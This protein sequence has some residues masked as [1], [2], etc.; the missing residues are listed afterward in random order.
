MR[1]NTIRR[2]ELGRGCRKI[3]VRRVRRLVIG[4]GVLRRRGHRARIIRTLRMG[5]NAGGSVATGREVPTRNESSNFGRWK[6]IASRVSSLIV[7]RLRRRCRR[8]RGRRV[9]R[10][11]A[12][13]EGWNWHARIVSV[14]AGRWQVISLR[15]AQVWIMDE[16]RVLGRGVR[17]HLGNCCTQQVHNGSI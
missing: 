7:W 12:L 13:G 4:R 3:K 16:P 1:R 6:I 15:G 9:V 10:N 5:K 17:I 8:G 11:G 14:R 2:L